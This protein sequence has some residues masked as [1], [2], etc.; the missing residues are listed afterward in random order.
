[1]TTELTQ[2]HNNVDKRNLIQKRIKQNNGN[3]IKIILI[4]LTMLRIR[5]NQNGHFTEA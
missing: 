1:M 3:N 4:L 5:V 2:F